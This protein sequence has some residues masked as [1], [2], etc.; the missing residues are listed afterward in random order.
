MRVWEAL[1][2]SLIFF[3]LGSGFERGEIKYKEELASGVTQNV[4]TLERNVQRI[5]FGS[6]NKHDLA[7]PLWK[8]INKNDLDGWIWLGDAIYADTRAIPIVL[9]VTTPIPEM[10]ERYNLQRKLPE[11]ATLIAEL[12]NFVFGIWDDH[13]YG[14][15]NG[16]TNYL[17]KAESQEVYL[18]F[19]A[20]SPESIRWT[21]SGLYDSYVWMNKAGEQNVRLI[22][23]D[24]RY[25]RTD[26]DILGAEQWEW[27]DKILAENTAQVTLFATGLQILPYDKVFIAETWDRFSR[28]RFLALLQTHNT[29]NPVIL[30]GDIH[31]AEALYRSACSEAHYPVHEVTSSGMTHS[32]LSALDGALNRV[33]IGYMVLSATQRSILQA[34]DLYEMLNWGTLEFDWQRNVI[35]FLAHGVN[36]KIAIN[37]T[38][39][40]LPRSSA[41]PPSAD[42]P[43][44]DKRHELNWRTKFLI[45]IREKLSF[46]ELGFIIISIP[47]LFIT[48]SC[49]Y[50]CKKL[51]S[52]YFIVHI[53]FCIN[54]TAFQ[55]LGT[56][57]GVLAAK[58][59]A[60]LIVG[61]NCRNFP[62]ARR[63][64]VRSCPAANRSTVIS[65][66][67]ATILSPICSM[68]YS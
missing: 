57:G 14:I 51:L 5:G 2:F 11:Y 30:S 61:W 16:D 32:A 28:K 21:R 63:F 8:D 17:Q 36:N 18:E 22:L 60:W 46:I 58:A 7:Q 4:I 45:K 53:A 43:D 65:R 19:L 56:S 67:I 6:C 1:C 35:Q 33:G 12:G 9:W 48:V 66:S 29:N 3:Q 40:I 44:V 26:T 38:I 24:V 41:H 59:L 47:L 20:E 37:Y 50:L 52:T 10:R 64:F 62:A 55:P 15:N 39:P 27:L 34:A 13:D 25:F 49:C 54:F 31:Y 42:C 23:L 68:E